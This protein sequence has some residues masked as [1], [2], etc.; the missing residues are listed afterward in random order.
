MVARC[1]TGRKTLVNQN[2]RQGLKKI[3]RLNGDNI[4]D[5]KKSGK[6][7][8]KYSLNL[9]QPVLRRLSGFVLILALG[10]CSSAPAPDHRPATLSS[11]KPSQGPIEH[12]SVRSTAKTERQWRHAVRMRPLANLPKPLLAKV[13]TPEKRLQCVPY[14]RQ[15]SNIQIRGNAW[16]WWDQAEGR[17]SRTNLPKAGSV[18]V[19]KRKDNSGSLGHVAY[20]QE[21]IDSR[22][23]IVSHANWLNE[24]RLHNHTPV[25]DVSKA[26]DWSDVRFWHTPGKHFGGHVYHPYGFILPNQTFASR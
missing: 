5:A 3:L 26:N 10:A 14:A 2:F 16:T 9:E 7:L 8:M 23:I 19:L 25:L 22:M 24:G 11:I 13:V 6:I 21:I 1:S 12:A 20:V 15:L 17:Y 18:M 4:K